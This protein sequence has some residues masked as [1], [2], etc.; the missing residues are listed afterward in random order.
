MIKENQDLPVTLNRSQVDVLK[1]NRHETS[2]DHR[3][4]A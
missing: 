4:Y 1:E 2:S 3:R